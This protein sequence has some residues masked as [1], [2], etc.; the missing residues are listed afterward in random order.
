MFCGFDWWAFVVTTP[1]KS[2]VK[3]RKP[4]GDE[5][6]ELH[7]GRQLRDGNEHLLLE[8]ISLFFRT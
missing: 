2:R 5:Q 7:L 4:H 8:V 3:T 6:M 1:Q